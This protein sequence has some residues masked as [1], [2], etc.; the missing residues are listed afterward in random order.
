MS[1]EFL[2]RRAAREDVGAIL[3][4]LADY[5]LRKLKEAS[6]TS[7]H[8]AAFDGISRD[9]NQYLAVAQL[10]GVTIGC[11]Q[12][13]F[14]P[15]LSRNGMERCQIEGVRIARHL[16]GKGLG[17]QMLQWAI[18][19]SRDRGCGLVQ[20]F[21]D[22]KRLDAHRFYESL[23]FEANHQGFRLYLQE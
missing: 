11:L 16:R 5:D 3:A 6:V 15:G 18:A 1:R 13:T 8:L 12:L 4:L 22:K 17:K 14:I 7:R 10:G 19:T 2:I 21:M 20:L 9:S 23:G